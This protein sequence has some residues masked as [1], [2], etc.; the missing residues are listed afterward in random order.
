[1]NETNEKE[2]FYDFGYFF[3]H[4]D[5]GSI[6]VTT[7]NELD[8]DDID[9]AVEYCLAHGMEDFE[10]YADNIVYIEELTK[11]EADEMGFFD[12]GGSLHD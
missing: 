8:V 12:K 6:R 1:M 9:S 4:K 2:Y 11:E 3:S 7:K 5:S 10:M